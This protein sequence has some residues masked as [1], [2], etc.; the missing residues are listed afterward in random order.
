MAKIYVVKQDNNNDVIGYALNVNQA[1]QLGEAKG[2]RWHVD[3]YPLGKVID[4]RHR[5][6]AYPTDQIVRGREIPAFE[7][8]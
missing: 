1:R 6:T 7:F 4:E 2:G 8:V 5:R 3:E